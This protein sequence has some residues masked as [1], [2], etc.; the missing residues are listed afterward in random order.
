[1][2]KD[3][4]TR[5]RATPDRVL[6]L[7]ADRHRDGAWPEADYKIK[8][9][10]WGKKHPAFKDALRALIRVEDKHELDQPERVLLRTHLLEDAESMAWR[11]ALPSQAPELWA[12]RKGT[13]ETPD[14]FIRRVY[15]RWLGN[16]LKRSHLLT[17]D[18]PLYTALSVWLHRHPE[19]GLPELDA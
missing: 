12:N 16:G 10:P 7:F 9:L 4:R 14:K 3:Q 1:M 15:A 13:Q 18:K 5:T 2:A 11:P 17:L 6:G 19:T 8:D